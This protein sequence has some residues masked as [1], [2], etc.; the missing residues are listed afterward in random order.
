METDLAEIKVKGKKIKV[1]SIRIN[2][3][4]IVVTG[5]WLRTATVEDE[6]WLE[7]QIVSDPEVFIAGLKQTKPKADIFTF[8]QKL[9]D[10]K[11]KYQ[12]HF[13]WDNVAAIPTT[14]YKEWWEKKLPQVTRKSVR[15]GIKRGVI[16][17]VSR[18]DDALVKG[19]VGIHN[20]TLMKQG[21]P[22]A[23][24]GKEFDIVKKEYGTYLDRSE[25]LGAYYQNEL[26]GIIKLVYI[27]ELAS[28]MQIITMDQHYDKRP[29]NILIT[30]AVE[31]CE[32][33][34]ISFL[35]YG[36]YVYGNKTDSSLTEFKRRNGFEKIEHP[37]YFIPLSLKGRIAIRFKLYLGLLG[38]LPS[39]VISFLI[40]LRSRY[41]K[42]KMKLLKPGE[43]LQNRKQNEK[44]TDTESEDD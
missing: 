13:E 7:G 9:P 19:I 30:K 36:K 39:G 8:A 24:Y 15:R 34:G 29:T 43:K 14:S 16:A 11:P 20:S 21:G 4:T 18:F 32:K 17:E 33:K 40:D 35:I 12:Y 25:F 44:Q 28:I 37:R 42:I 22:F 31:V 6:E 1:P 41:Y 10:T 26:I 27:D 3:K 38:I 5:K 2:N 23:H